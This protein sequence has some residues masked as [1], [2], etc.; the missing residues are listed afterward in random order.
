MRYYLFLTITSEYNFFLKKSWHTG[1]L[2]AAHKV[3]EHSAK[4]FVYC[5]MDK[6]SGRNNYLAAPKYLSPRRKSYL[7]III[8]K[9][10]FC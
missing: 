8:K 3:S 6:Q 2:V 9:I 5:L 7:R 10:R 1:K 4:M